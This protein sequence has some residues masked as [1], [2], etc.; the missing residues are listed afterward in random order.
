ME[1]P[2]LQPVL[3][4]GIMDVIDTLLNQRSDDSP[5]T[6]TSS[7]DF[8]R[9][10]QAFLDRYQIDTIGP[11]QMRVEPTSDN[12]STLLIMG[13]INSQTGSELAWPISSPLNN[14]HVQGRTGARAS[15]GSGSSSVSVQ[16]VR[17]LTSTSY[18][19]QSSYPERNM[20]VDGNDI[21]QI[22]RFRPSGTLKD[23]NTN[24]VA[25]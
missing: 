22:S 6:R 17:V 14:T 7:S 11:F 13:E 20:Q 8:L 16:Y 5:P 23:L 21:S 3:S 10:L 4:I 18:Q 19:E 9:S 12:N 2:P 1:V 15:R 25:S 24:H